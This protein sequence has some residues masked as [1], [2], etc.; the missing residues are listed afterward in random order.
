MIDIEEPK[1][2]IVRET[3]SRLYPGCRVQLLKY[4]ESTD[5]YRVKNV[6][7]NYI[8]YIKA[9]DLKLQ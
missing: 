4:I 9:K 1:C 6:E 5:Q 2:A 8:C 7:S 3:A